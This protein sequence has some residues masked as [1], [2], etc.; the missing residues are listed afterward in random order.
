MNQEGC[1]KISS[2]M[3]E[4][5]YAW[6]SPQ[7]LSN[8]MNKK[9]DDIESTQALERIEVGQHDALSATA[10]SLLIYAKLYQHFNSLYNT[11]LFC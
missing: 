5:V 10:V 2:R 7:E 4:F 3:P 9:I 1:I 8:Q 6:F 11:Y